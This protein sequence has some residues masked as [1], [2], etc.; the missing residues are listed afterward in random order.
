MKLMKIAGVVTACALVAMAGMA[1]EAEAKRKKPKSCFMAG[2]DGTAVT[3]E[4]ARNNA[5]TAL[6]NV[7][8]KEKAKGVGKVKYECTTTAVVVDNCRASQRACR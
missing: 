3:A 1:D 4:L 2:G 5:R 8:A 7:I 6:D